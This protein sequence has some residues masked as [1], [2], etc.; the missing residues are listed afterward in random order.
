[1]FQT[2]V[3]AGQPALRARTPRQ[4]TIRSHIE[5]MVFAIAFGFT[6][7]LVLGLIP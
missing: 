5:T 3:R 6:V 4:S 2:S 1:M 7:A